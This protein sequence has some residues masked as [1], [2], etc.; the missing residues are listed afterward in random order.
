MPNTLSWIPTLKNEFYWKFIIW[1]VFFHILVCLQFRISTHFYRHVRTIKI[2][3][4]WFIHK[5]I[6]KHVYKNYINWI[7]LFID[8]N[9]TTDT[10][11]KFYSLF[12]EV[13][14]EMFSLINTPLLENVNAPRVFIR[15]N[16]VDRGCRGC[17]HMVARF[18]TTYAISAFHH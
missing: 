1:I 5:T 16:T 11:V 17:D 8:N 12:H 13:K 4:H 2:I 3:F 14:L 15:R 6:I 10:R 7:V 18:T 9:E